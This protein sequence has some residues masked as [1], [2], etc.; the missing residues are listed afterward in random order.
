MEELG[1]GLAFGDSLHPVALTLVAEE[2]FLLL[3]F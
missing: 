2:S 1:C 3:S